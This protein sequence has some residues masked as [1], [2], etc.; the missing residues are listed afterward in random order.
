MCALTAVLCTAV[1][2]SVDLRAGCTADCVVNVFALAEFYE[3]HA[4]RAVP[5]YP[6]KVRKIRRLECHFSE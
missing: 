4:A 1:H 5:R 6:S 3:L 2:T